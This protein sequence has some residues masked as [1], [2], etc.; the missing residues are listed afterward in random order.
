MALK[1]IVL[2]KLCCN[3]FR[4]VDPKDCSVSPCFGKVNNFHSVPTLKI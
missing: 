1:V 2:F 4:K 3:K